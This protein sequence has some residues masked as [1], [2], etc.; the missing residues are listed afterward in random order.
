M[1]KVIANKLDIII[2]ILSRIEHQI[3][4]SRPEENDNAYSDAMQQRR[5]EFKRLFPSNPSNPEEQE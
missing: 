5:E 4:P 3:T 1:L 2:Q